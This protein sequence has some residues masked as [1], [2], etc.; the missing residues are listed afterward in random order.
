MK[1]YARVVII[2]SSYMCH[3]GVF[4]PYQKCKSKCM[5]PFVQIDPVPCEETVRRLTDPKTDGIVENSYQTGLTA[6]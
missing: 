5:Y 4:I 1:S 3:L 2:L 6:V